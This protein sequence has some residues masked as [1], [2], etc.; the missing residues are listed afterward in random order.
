ML[1]G[2]DLKDQTS[3]DFDFSGFIKG[4]VVMFA[5]NSTVECAVYV[6]TNDGKSQTVKCIFNC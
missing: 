4:F 2:D 6:E 3:V 5:P 1:L